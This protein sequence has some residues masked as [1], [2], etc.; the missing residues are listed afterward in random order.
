M[1]AFLSYTLGNVANAAVKVDVAAVADDGGNLYPSAVAPSACSLDAVMVAVV[2][3]ASALVD[4]LDQ[5]ADNL[6]LLVAS[7]NILHILVAWADN[8]HASNVCCTR[9]SCSLPRDKECV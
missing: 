8:L 2:V 9:A 5:L 4:I 1:D 6:R 7:G 3:V